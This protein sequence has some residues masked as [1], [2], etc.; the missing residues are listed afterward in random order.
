MTVSTAST[1]S[2]LVD[3]ERLPAKGMQVEIVA[4]D[5]Q[6]E[7]LAESY[8]LLSV[9]DFRAELVVAGWRRDGVRVSGRVRAHIT[10][11]CVATLAPVD[12]A[13]DAGISALFV[14][15]GSAL[16]RNEVDGGELV[17]DAE[18]DDPPEPFSGKR[19]DVGR[20]AEEFFV[21]AIDPY[22]RAPGAE[23]EPAPK[24]G[25]TSPGDAVSGE[26]SAGPMHD[27]LRKLVQKG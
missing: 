12:A 11:A 18:G 7:A 16:A 2:F 8:D 15:E 25:D 6:R 21:L 10:Q 20:I 1:L 22:P 13:I 9:E 17:L 27:A 14:P 19:I 3:V 26:E 24:S 4:D 23:L 5:G